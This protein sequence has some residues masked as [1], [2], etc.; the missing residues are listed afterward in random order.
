VRRIKRGLTFCHDGI[1]A[2]HLH[3]HRYQWCYLYAFVHPRTG[4]T[5]RLL[6][7]T[8]SI[9]AFTI[10]L[11]EFAQ[12]IGAGQGK[13]VLL[14][15]DSAGWHVSPQVRVP[16]GLHLHFLPPYSPELQPAER[17]WSLTNEALANR[18]FRD[19]DDLQ[20]VQAQRCLQL[21]AMPQMI[22]TQTNFHWWPQIA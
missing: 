5:L 19:L 4:R 20:A 6:L 14:V 12:A 10:A 15:R 21:Q 17:L 13:Q 3:Q 7:P 11:A 9:A 8:V 1:S 18:H 16:A 22:E 2:K